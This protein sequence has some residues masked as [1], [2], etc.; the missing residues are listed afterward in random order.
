M[1]DGGVMHLASDYIHPTPNG[2]RCRARIFVPDEE[3]DAPVI[4]L[5][6]QRNNPGMSVT[7]CAGR[8]AAE[9]VA[10]HRWPDRTSPVWIEHYEDGVRGTREDPQTFDLVSFGESGPPNSP[11]WSPLDRET[12][13]ALVGQPVQ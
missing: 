10:H 8:L 12:V 7:N 5:T 1:Y 11:R 4:V 2:G 6:E 13:E 3:R 9:I